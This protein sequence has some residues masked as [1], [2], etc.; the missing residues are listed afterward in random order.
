MPSFGVLVSPGVMATVHQ[1]FFCV[2]IDPAVDDNEGGRSLV[3]SEVEAV[4]LPEG[5][6]NPYGNA[7]VMQ[8]WQKPHGNAFVMQ[9]RAVLPWKR[10]RNAC[11]HAERW[12]G[13]EGDLTHTCAPC[14]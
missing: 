13:L 10:G 7:F 1:H 4:A 11:A 5:A 12:L 6:Q 8:V 14:D 2:R 9:V 3:V